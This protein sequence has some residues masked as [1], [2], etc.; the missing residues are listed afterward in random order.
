L[1]GSMSW[2]WSI[3]TYVVALFTLFNV[4]SGRLF[5]GDCGSYTIGVLAVLGS[6]SGINNGILSVGFLAALFSYPCIEMVLTLYRRIKLGRSPFLPDN[7]HFHNRLNHFL[8]SRFST[9]L[10]ANSGTGLAIACATSGSVVS[11]LM[12]DILA[13][14]DEGW[15]SVFAGLAGL[16]VLLFNL[17][18]NS[19][20]RSV[21]F[22]V[23][24]TSHDDT[25]S[26]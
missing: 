6:F 15:W 8:K 22:V 9:A 20:A 2:V 17:L 1:S 16:H 4:V 21:Q 12:L 10:L 25:A 7:D 5:L 14:G 23:A 13:M 19:A 26:V 18:G 24:N 11:F 3:L